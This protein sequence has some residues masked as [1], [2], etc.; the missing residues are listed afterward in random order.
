MLYTY[1]PAQWH[2]P[3]IDISHI[4]VAFE[5]F[6]SKTSPCHCRVIIIILNECAALARSSLSCLMA[7]IS[8]PDLPRPLIRNGLTYMYAR[9]GGSGN[10]SQP[11]DLRN[12]SS[13]L[14]ANGTDLI[15]VEG[16]TTN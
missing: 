2:A 6:G 14:M 7:T 1:I 5:G 11:G 10:Q 16:P 13:G 9:V 12:P 15:S 4:W 3:P 8:A